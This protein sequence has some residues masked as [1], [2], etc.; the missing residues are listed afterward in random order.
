[1]VEI[2]ELKDKALICKDCRK[3]FVF[4]IWEQKLFGQRGWASPTRCP[5]CRQRRRILR[6]ALEDGISISDQGVHEATCAKCETKFL[7]VLEIKQNEKEYCALCW[8]EIKG[9]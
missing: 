3:D 9:F 1:M 8:K 5:I 7:S 6:T 2:E 4:T